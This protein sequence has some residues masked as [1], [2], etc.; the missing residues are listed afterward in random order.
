M[1]GIGIAYASGDR[2]SVDEL[3]GFLRQIGHTVTCKGYEPE[4][5]HLTDPDRAELDCRDCVVVVWSAQSRKSIW[6]RSMAERARDV[7]KLVEI[8]L[9]EPD[10]DK[11][12]RS[13]R[14]ATFPVADLKAIRNAVTKCVAQ[15][16]PYW[17][18]RLPSI[19]RRIATRH[20]MALGAVFVAF[21]SFTATY[22]G[23]GLEP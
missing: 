16:S 23:L 1:S 22:M 7:D 17:R 15:P 19:T 21:V 20:L 3:A 4:E 13:A 5:H 12:H 10:R 2:R 18:D 8:A 14:S 11:M 9:D 6:V